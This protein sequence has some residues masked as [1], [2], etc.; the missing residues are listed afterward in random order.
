MQHPTSF[1]LP[2]SK[3]CRAA[4]YG[5]PWEDCQLAAQRSEE[6]VENGFA[7]VWQDL[8]CANV[9]YTGPGDTFNHVLSLTPGPHTLWTGIFVMVS[10]VGDPSSVC[11]HLTRLLRP[12]QTT[13][14]IVGW[15]QAWIEL[16]DTLGPLFPSPVET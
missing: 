12:V 15:Q 14:V 1:L 4:V 2:A 9:S 8:P 5:I 11:T 16:V 13:D 10:A 6:I 3:S 7:P